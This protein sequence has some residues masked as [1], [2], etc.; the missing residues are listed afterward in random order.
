M[1]VFSAAEFS[2]YFEPFSCDVASPVCLNSRHT[3][4]HRNLFLITSLWDWRDSPG[5]TLWQT[6]ICNKLTWWHTCVWRVVQHRGS[7]VSHIAPF[8]TLGSISSLKTSQMPADMFCGKHG[9]KTAA[10]EIK[11]WAS[12]WWILKKKSWFR[13][14]ISCLNDQTCF[15]VLQKSSPSACN[16]SIFTVSV[17]LK[18]CKAVCAHAR[19][20]MHVSPFKCYLLRGEKESAWAPV[21]RLGPRQ[22]SPLPAR[23][24]LLSSK[25]R[26]PQ[27]WGLA[28]KPVY[29]D[30]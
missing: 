18:P 13:G 7:H 23:W 1:F 5:V 9:S 17:S 4:T 19:M 14:Y 21:G 6:A 15:S 24:S 3:H 8:C 2:Q 26:D 22:R 20:S 29:S 11:Q 28:H 25:S 16:L 12:V 30:L 10:P 27:R